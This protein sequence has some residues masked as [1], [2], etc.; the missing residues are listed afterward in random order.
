M[1]ELAT[2]KTHWQPSVALPIGGKCEKM[3]L[4]KTAVV[5]IT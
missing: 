2:N 1:N 4:N 3:K 5:E